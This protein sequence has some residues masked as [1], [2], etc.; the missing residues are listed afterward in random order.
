[1][2]LENNIKKMWNKINQKIFIKRFK[3]IIKKIEI[4][5]TRGD[6]LIIQ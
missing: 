4:L 3:S 2:D 6:K 1:M 5:K